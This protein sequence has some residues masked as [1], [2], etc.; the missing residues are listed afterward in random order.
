MLLKAN[1][2]HFED[3]I[4]TTNNIYSVDQLFDRFTEAMQ[5][6]GFDRIIFSVP[7]DQDLPDDDNRIGLFQNYP[8]DWQK[9]YAEKDFAR[10]DPVLQAAGTYPWAFRWRD[11][12]RSHA[13]SSRQI[14]FFRL[15]EEA[16]LH[17]GVGIPLHGDRAQIAGVALATSQKLDACRPSLDLV[18]AYCNQFYLSFKRLRHRREKPEAIV[19][20]LSKKEQEILHWVATGISDDEIG[21]KLNISANTVDTHL[22]HIYQKLEVNNRV[23]AVVKGIL[24]GLI[25]L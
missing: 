11:I 5:T 8:D 4:E 14:R 22:R 12:E 18:S 17:N 21:R 19:A 23:G 9:Y 1:G 2:H 13:L 6:Y 25:H 10:I 20:A 7:R 3:F 16:G 24:A 15:G